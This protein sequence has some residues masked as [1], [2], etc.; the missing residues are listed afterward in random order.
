MCLGWILA[1]WCLVQLCDL[2][3]FPD[4]SLCIWKHEVE[5][6]AV[7]VEKALR[8]GDQVWLAQC[9]ILG[10]RDLSNS[11]TIGESN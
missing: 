10:L 11:I 7:S 3:I 5:G 8:G 2:L 1:V 6:S 4:L 9:H